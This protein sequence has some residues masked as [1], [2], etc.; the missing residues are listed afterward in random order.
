M[1]SRPKEADFSTVE[2]T[3]MHRTC[4]LKH[5]M[6]LSWTKEHIFKNNIGG[7]LWFKRE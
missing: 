4:D 6:T 5:D 2:P 7:H 1:A 3:I